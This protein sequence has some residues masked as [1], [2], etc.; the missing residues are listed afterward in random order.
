MNPDKLKTWLSLVSQKTLE[1]KVM[2]DI[3]T[4]N[5]VLFVYYDH[6]TSM[7]YLAGKVHVAVI[8]III[9]VLN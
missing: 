6:D 2:E 3:D 9:I 7:I 1:E 5:G 8:F 4:S